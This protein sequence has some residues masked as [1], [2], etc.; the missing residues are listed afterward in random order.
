M[1]YAF[2]NKQIKNCQGCP[3]F[4]PEKC[5]IGSWE[6]VEYNKWEREQPEYA[7][8]KQIK[9]IFSNCRLMH[10]SRGLSENGTW[11]MFLGNYK[12]EQK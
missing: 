2:H 5:K 9:K 3:F 1:I 4:T 11:S 10:I 6:F 12:D 8:G 7:K